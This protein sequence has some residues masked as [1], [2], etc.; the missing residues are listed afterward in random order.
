ML[1]LAQA[2]PTEKE[3]SDE[4]R[5]EEERHHPFDRQ[6]RSKNVADIVRVVRPVGTELKFEC[7]AGGYTHRKIDTEQLA[8]EFCHVTV[9]FFTGH[10]I[11]R[12]HDDQHPRQSQR[13]RDE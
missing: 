3:Q 13:Q 5:F 2:I 12:L 9:D 8:P 1:L 10:D 6:R 11:D 4:S 7:D